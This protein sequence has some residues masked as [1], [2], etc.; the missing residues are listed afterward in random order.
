MPAKGSGSPMDAM[1]EAKNC[2][3]RVELW[4]FGFKHG[5]M[6]ANLVL[7]VRFVPNPYYIHALREMTGKESA[8]SEYVFKDSSTRAFVD[9]LAELADAMVHAFS[10]QGRGAVRIAVGCT[11]GQHRS[12][13]IVEAL[14]A[15]LA[16]KSISVAIRHRELE[17]AGCS[18]RSATPGTATPSEP[19][20]R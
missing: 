4:S 17:K 18:H 11:G 9:R 19:M 10:Q 20:M 1:S 2:G 12:V 13:A 6:E 5:A 3:P 14:G 8:C 7:D 16:R 15:S